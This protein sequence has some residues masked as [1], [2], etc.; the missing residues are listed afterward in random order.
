MYLVFSSLSQGRTL[1]TRI[2]RY[3]MLRDPPAGDWSLAD[4]VYKP[5]QYKLRDSVEFP[6]VRVDT[7]ANDRI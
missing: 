7:I 2:D 4:D 1:E 6:I 5:K 3:V